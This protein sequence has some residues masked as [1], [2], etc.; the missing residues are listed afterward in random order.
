MCACPQGVSTWTKPMPPGPAQ[1][2]S[3]PTVSHAVPNG[4]AIATTEPGIQQTQ[5][6]AQPPLVPPVVSTGTTPSSTAGI[7]FN[8]AFGF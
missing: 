4:H 5:S 3:P 2:P 7:N 8:G 1:S 6:M